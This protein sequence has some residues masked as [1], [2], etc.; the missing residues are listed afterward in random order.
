[1]IQVEKHTILNFLLLLVALLEHRVTSATYYVIPDDYSL[2]HTDANTFSLQHYLNNTSKYFVS[3]NQFHFIQGQYYVD[4][5]LIIEDIDNFTI[6]GPRIG[7]STI[8]CTSPASIV[9]LNAAAIKFLNI[10][11]V[12]CIRNHKDYI[13]TLPMLS[14]YHNK[15][16][17]RDSI[18]FSKLTDYYTS[19]LIWNS[20][21]VVIYN[22][23]INA[24]VNTSFTAFLIVNVKDSS[25]V[26]VKVQVITHTDY[27]ETFNNHPK[28]INGLKLFVYFYN[29]S[30]SGSL[31]IDNFTTTLIKHV[32]TTCSV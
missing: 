1:M 11:L 27:C 12:N 3:H 18:W 16:Y 30:G 21:S 10:S 22:M 6:T 14:D 4:R 23:N 29:I 5:D 32:Q 26:N 15:L 13:N 24:T 25:L 31:T 19:L 8:T 28:E 20:S 17:A 9:V 2:H 7:Q